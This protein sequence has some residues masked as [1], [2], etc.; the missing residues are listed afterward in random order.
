ML[1][2]QYREE[3]SNQRLMDSN[4]HNI[5]IFIWLICKGKHKEVY[6]YALITKIR[7]C[8]CWN[9][10]VGS[11]TQLMLLQKSAHAGLILDYFV[12]PQQ[13]NIPQIISE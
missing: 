6:K 4:Y 11:S 8:M 3:K 10:V 12:F 5:G 2:V 9:M 13:V 7:I 1:I